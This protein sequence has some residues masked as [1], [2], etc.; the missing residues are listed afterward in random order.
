MPEQATVFYSWQSDLPNRTNRGLIEEALRK[1]AKAVHKSKV[2]EV[3]PIVDRDTRGTPGS[4][5]ILATI[6]K[7][8]AASFVFVADVSIVTR[9]QDCKPCPNP[10]VLLELGYALRSLGDEKVIVVYN[11]AFGTLDEL[12]FDLRGRRIAAYRLAPDEQPALAKQQLALVLQE[13]LTGIAEHRRL[14]ANYQR[15]SGFATELIS[16]LIR[17]QLFGNERSKRRLSPWRERVPYEYGK[18]SQWLTDHSHETVAQ[19][20]GLREFLEDLAVLLDAVKSHVH[21]LGGPDKSA[22]KVLAATEAAASLQNELM[23]KGPLTDEAKTEIVSMLGD[24][25][26]RLAAWMHRVRD[27]DLYASGRYEDFKTAI[28]E[29]GFQLSYISYFPF[30]WPEGASAEEVRGIGETLHLIGLTEELN[31]HKNRA[32]ILDLIHI[33]EIKLRNLLQGANILKSEATLG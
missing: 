19:D 23:R 33:N 15:N 5:D 32:S 10:N 16:V 6:L 25:H 31:K 30:D 28:V 11:T 27:S 26:K 8:I 22:K 14:D 13:A 17:V 24:Q 21:I 4:P 29:I 18:L 2:F 7:K 1:A 20:L 9:A 12:P 3:E